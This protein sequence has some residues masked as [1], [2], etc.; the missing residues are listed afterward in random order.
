[1]YDKEDNQDIGFVITTT[2][3]IAFLSLAVIIIIN[4]IFTKFRFILEPLHI[5]LISYFVGLLLFLIL[6][7]LNGIQMVFFPSTETC[8]NYGFSLFASVFGSLTIIAMQIDRFIAIKWAIY[9]SGIV[10]NT[11]S[12]YVILS[13]V[14]IALIESIIIIFVTDYNYITKEHSTPVPM[15]YNMSHRINHV[16]AGRHDEFTII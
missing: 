10:D 4:R 8:W 3:F 2:S 12:I 5:F 9:Y 13:C 7:I 15:S 11:K 6:N 1:M 14:A 16:K